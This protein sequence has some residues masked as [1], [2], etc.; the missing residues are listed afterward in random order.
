MSRIPLNQLETK[1]VT[2]GVLTALAVRLLNH[3]TEGRSSRVCSDYIIE[4]TP[5]HRQ[6]LVDM[7]YWNGDEIAIK[8]LEK[9]GLSVGKHGL[10]TQDW[11][12]S[13]YIQHRLGHMEVEGKPEP[14]TP[15]WFT[16]GQAVQL[17]EKHS[18]GENVIG[19]LRHEGSVPGTRHL[20]L[21]NSFDHRDIRPEEVEPVRFGLWI[22]EQK[23]LVDLRRRNI[24]KNYQGLIDKNNAEKREIQSVCP[25][26]ETKRHP[27]A[28]GNNDWADECLDCGAFGKHLKRKGMCGVEGI[29]R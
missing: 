13:A 22:R 15:N 5:E 29:G 8:E 4:D 1:P 2:D 26:E 3:F 28:S 23:K 11:F 9:E 18:D 25:H 27:D 12:L 24:D 20:M 14:T 19:L 17:K 16:D 10:M 6:L 21:V 7:Q